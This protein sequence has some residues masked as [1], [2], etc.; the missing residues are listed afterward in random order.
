VI[1]LIFMLIYL[2][3]GIITFPVAT[4]IIYKREYDKYENALLAYRDA[5]VVGGAC[6]IFWPIAIPA[7]V[8]TEA[9]MTAARVTA[10]P[11]V[12][13][14]IT[15]HNTL[16]LERSLGMHKHTDELPPGDI[17]PHDDPPHLGRTWS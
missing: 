8:L 16:M 5:L 12:K 15:Q 14:L 6:G 9:A 7:A 17:V 13:K 10:P 11:E 1:E 4:R 3:I 2:G